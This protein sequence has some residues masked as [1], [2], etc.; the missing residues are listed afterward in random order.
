MR[1]GGDGVVGSPIVSQKVP[2]RRMAETSDSIRQL[3]FLAFVPYSASAQEV[4]CND[5]AHFRATEVGIPLG[6]T[7]CHT[8]LVL[9]QL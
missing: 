9:A 4:A 1:G 3:S 5:A 6:K 2:S 7:N 8:P